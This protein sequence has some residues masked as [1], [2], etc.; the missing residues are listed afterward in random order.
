MNLYLDTIIEKLE[1][2]DL[3][4]NFM[5]ELSEAL[6]NF[7]KKNQLKGEKMDY[8]E[9]TQEEDMEF[10]RKKWDFL[11]NYFNKEL[12]DLS[13][14][15]IFIVTNKYENDYEYHRYKITQ[16]KNLK[17]CK[18]IAFEKDLPE[19]VKLGDVVRKID[20]KYIYD[21]QATKYVTDS[22]NKIKEDIIN[23]RWNIGK[24]IKI[25]AS[26]AKKIKKKVQIKNYIF[27]KLGKTITS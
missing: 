14:G 16:Y 20:G 15:E 5:K 7:N 2:N 4:K 6:E 26:I 10:Y 9:L 17:E 22:I 21:E 1:Q 12:S 19:N 3:I 25:L 27:E 18:Y 8:I 13:K 23:K 11:E 24:T